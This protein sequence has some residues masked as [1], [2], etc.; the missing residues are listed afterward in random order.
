MY[1]H[2]IIF[3]AVLTAANSLAWAA[4]AGQ[5][6]ADPS[7]GPASV[8]R[9]FREVSRELD[10]PRDRAALEQICT[11]FSRTDPAAQAPTTEWMVLSFNQRGVLEAVRVQ[12]DILLAAPSLIQRAV[13]LHE[14]EHVTRAPETARRL[15]RSSGR[16]PS[17]DRFRRVIRAVV[18]DEYWAYRRDILYVYRA[19]RA[20]GGLPAYLKTLPPPHRLP[21]QR[22]YRQAVEPFLA[23]DGTV[24]ERRL[25]RDGIFFGTF[26]HQYPRYYE[27]AL[28]WE[29][30][31]G[32][33]EI[34]RGSDG[35]LRPTRLLTPTVFLTW[36]TP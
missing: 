11:V 16:G 22:Y 28:A 13:I 19:V 29:A 23:P 31:Q 6:V 24:N 15:N 27:A 25:R 10:E 35:I 18:D 26:P 17:E 1:K 12:A 5:P 8:I 20:H 21:M 7:T 32:H 33:V 14:V 4:W 30:L 9:F 36:L 2:T 3:I 34:R